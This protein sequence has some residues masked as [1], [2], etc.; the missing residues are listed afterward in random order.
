MPPGRPK[1][2]SNATKLGIFHEMIRENPGHL[3]AISEGDSWFSYPLNA[4]LPDFFRTMAPLNLLRLEKSGDEARKMLAPQGP[5]LKKLRKYLK[6]YGKHLQLLAFSGG[7]NDILDEN[8][9]GMLLKRK[10]G[11]SWRQC[12]NDVALSSRLAEVAQCYGRLIALRDSFAP[13]CQIVT[14]TYD[15]LIPTGK[16]A[17]V[18]L[19]LVRVGPWIRPVLVKFGIPD[20]QEGTQLVRHLVDQF[21]VTLAQ[22][23]VGTTGFHVVDSRGTLSSGSADWNDEIHPTHRGFKA[24]SERWRVTFA[25]LFPAQGF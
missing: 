2:V 22:V 13:K 23:A 8:L 15:Y 1:N 4:N 9:P 11:M 3:V 18:P 12:V 6:L 14:H 24:I 19:G 5:Q 17:P 25:R 16:G 7:G 21:A 10:P 20:P